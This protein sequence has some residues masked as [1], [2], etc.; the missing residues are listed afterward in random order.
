MAISNIKQ[1]KN[2]IRVRESR[3]RLKEKCIS[4]KGSKCSAC[5]YNKCIASLCFHHTSGK[6]FNISSATTT[7]WEVIKSELN[8]CVLL[9]HNCHNEIHHNERVKEYDKLKKEVNYLTKEE[10]N[11][12]KKCIKCLGSVP[13]I[14]KYCQF[15]KEEI[16]NKSHTKYDKQAILALIYSSSLEEIAEKL[17]YNYGNLQKY[18]KRNNIKYFTYKRD[19]IKWPLDSDLQLMVKAKPLIYLAKELGVSN[20]TI[21]KRCK[22]LNIELPGRGYWLKKE[23]KQ[24]I[25]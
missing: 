6:D 25:I 3:R 11:Q 4:Y 13:N 14:G 17:T 21:K 22:K 2:K 1:I 18:C 24:Y 8:K 5:G 10:I 23:N 9:C 20:N 19:K 7:R 16:K 12:N 15:C